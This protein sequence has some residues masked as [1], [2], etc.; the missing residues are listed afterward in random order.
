MIDYGHDLLFGSFVT[1]SAQDPMAV[2]ALARSSEA[3]GLDLVT[4]QDHPYQPAFLDTWTLLSYVA[5]ATERSTCRPTSSTSRC[6]PPVVLARSAAS[7]DLLSGGRVELGL[8]AGA[9]W[10]AIEAAGGRRLSSGQAVDALKEAIRIICEV[11]DGGQCRGVRFDGRYYRV[12]GDKR[13]P[14]PAHDIPIWLGAYKPRMLGLTGRAADGWLPSLGYLPDPS[15]L[16][17]LNAIIDDSALEAGRRPEQIRRLLNV[18]GRF[19]STSD[20]L[21]VGRPEQMGRGSSPSWRS[22][23]ASR[24]SSSPPTMR[25]A[26]GDSVARSRLPYASSWSASAAQASRRRRGRPPPPA[27]CPRPTTGSGAAAGGSG[28]RSPGPPHRL[29]PRGSSSPRE[30]GRSHSTWSRCTTT[31]AAS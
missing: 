2:V 1:P 29:P 15:A 3:A 30:A 19:Q 24:R 21:L 17:D 7:L 9:F 5:A 18:S 10:E 11:W 20:G 14:T 26:C 8:G 31:C 25:R 13:G 12:M 4:F 23:T 22:P 6:G 16:A 27:W 28:T